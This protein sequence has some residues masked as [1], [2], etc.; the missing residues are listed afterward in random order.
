[1]KKASNQISHNITSKMIEINTLGD[2][3]A[4]PSRMC[5]KV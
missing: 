5:F 1:M 4:E 3:P 2:P